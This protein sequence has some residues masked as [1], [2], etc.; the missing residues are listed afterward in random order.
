MS[1]FVTPLII[2]TALFMEQLDGTVLATALP[3]MAADLHEDPV[4]LKLALTSYLLSLAVFIPLSGWAADRF[5]ARRVFRAAI[6]VFTFGSILCGLS[7]SLGAIVA[8]RIVQGLGG[9]MMTPV[10]RLVLLRTAPRHE[11]VRAMA[12]LTI[13]AL[14]GPMIGPPIGGFIATYFHWRYIFWINVPIGVLGVMLVTRFIPDLREEWTPPL[15]VAGAILSGVGL[16]CLVFGFTIAGR[17]FAPAPVVVLIVALGAGALFAYVRHARRTRYPIVDLDLLQIPTFRSAVFGGFL[18]RIGLGATPFL[19]PLLLQ[20]G[21]GLSA[22][23]A[24]L[25]TFVSAAGAMA[26]KTTAQPILRIFGFR[27]VLIVNALISAG[28]LAFNATF[29]AATPHM[30]IMGV[31]LVGGFFRSLEFTA[32]NAIAYADVDQDAMSRAT[33]FASVAQQLSL[34]TGV[35]IGAA[36]LEATRALRGGGALQAADF[37]PAFIVVALISMLSVASFLPLAPNAGDDLTGRGKRV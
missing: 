4:A 36:A 24:G 23:E 2:A 37:T 28:F 29:T 9:A 20:A 25:L 18:F 21:F 5:G 34:S 3:A 30:L 13:P 8:F 22:Y 19:L 26:M 15:D 33:S 6:I 10:G 35:A 7:N 31:L 11:L 12:Y 14:V 32:L 17:G 16:S 1:Y 27:R